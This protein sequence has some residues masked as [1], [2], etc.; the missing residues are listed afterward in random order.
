MAD[1]DTYHKNRSCSCARC[2]CSGYM[3]PAVLITLGVLFLID[4]VSPVGFHQTWPILLIVIGV[5]KV[6]QWNSPSS[7]HVEP[8]YIGPPPPVSTV[9]PPPAGTDSQVPH[10]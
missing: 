3:G 1:I 10:V 7:G 8:G 2:R 4:Q 5:V 6:M 9:P